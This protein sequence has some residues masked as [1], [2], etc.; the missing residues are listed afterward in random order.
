MLSGSLKA[1]I[2]SAFFMDVYCECV[3]IN[4]LHKEF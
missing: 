1:D 2:T 4:H 3:G